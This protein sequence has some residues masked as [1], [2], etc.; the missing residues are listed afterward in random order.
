MRH[1]IVYFLWIPE[2]TTNHN[3]GTFNFSYFSTFPIF[4]RFLMQRKQRPPPTG[5]RGQRKKRIIFVML[6]KYY[7]LQIS[8]SF[9]I[10]ARTLFIISKSVF[11][12]CEK[13]F[14]PIHCSILTSYPSFFKFSLRAVRDS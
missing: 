13:S 9:S 4:E 6:V 11:P 14:L 7:N 12:N 2:L 10:S 5:G 3:P 1:I 8:F